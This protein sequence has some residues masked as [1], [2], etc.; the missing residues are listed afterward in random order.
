M[1]KD[2]LK[3]LKEQ[4]DEFLKIKGVGLDQ[5]DELR[6]KLLLEMREKERKALA[7]AIANEYQ[8]KIEDFIAQKLSEAEKVHQEDKEKIIEAI[9]SVELKPRVEIP[10]IKFPEIKI[11]QPKVVVKPPDVKVPPIEIPKTIEIT[12]FFSFIK[13]LFEIL[14]GRLRVMIEGIDRKNPLPV[15]LVD[16]KGKFYKALATIVGRIGGGMGWEVVGLKDGS[17]ERINPAKEDGNLQKLE[18]KTPPYTGISDGRKTITVAG[19]RETLVASPTPCKR[20]IIMAMLSNT[21][22]IVVGGSTVVA[23]EATRQGIPI[24]AGQ[25]M[26]I[27]ISNVVSPTPCKRVIIMAMLSNTGEIV[28]GGSTVVAAEATRQG[29]PIT[30]GQ[31]IQI[32]I[33]DLYKIYLDATVGGEGVTFVY[34]T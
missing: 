20:V 12:G 26:Q 30:A 31:S 10:E 29:I 25:S 23:A 18:V 33:D 8:K 4:I 17:G 32:D 19:T 34:F 21:G 24:T 28:V 2:A 1:D 3:K 7:E 6:K 15:I 22:E 9:K 14:K 27:D 5:F 11:P 16:E 13:A